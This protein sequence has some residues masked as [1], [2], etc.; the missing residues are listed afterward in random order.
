M[1]GLDLGKLG[2]SSMPR[3]QGGLEKHLAKHKRQLQYS[4][5]KAI[6]ASN[7]RNGTSGTSG[8][9]WRPSPNPKLRIGPRLA[10]LEV[11][12]ERLQAGPAFLPWSAG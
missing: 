12:L 3:L 4:R 8:F 5:A 11:K 7:A 1:N 10:C 2:K 9:C 6:N